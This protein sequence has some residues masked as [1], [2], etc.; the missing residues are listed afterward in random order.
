MEIN[1]QIE[2]VLAHGADQNFGSSL[3]PLREGVDN[4]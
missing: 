1:S 2:G 3:V 4:P